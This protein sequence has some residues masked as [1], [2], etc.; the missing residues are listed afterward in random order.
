MSDLLP[1]F[2]AQLERRAGELDR[3]RGEA[4]AHATAPAA[5]HGQRRRRWRR[6]HG[7]GLAVVVL[8]AGASVGGLAYAAATT[9]WQPPLGNG[10][11]G[12]ATATASPVPAEQLRA[13]GVL[14]R[15]QT[16]LDRNVTTRY[17]LQFNA[18][19]E[20]VRTNAVRRLATGTSGGAIVLV[21]Y[22]RR[23]TTMWGDPQSPKPEALGDVLCLNYLDPFASAGVK[24]GTLNDV[25][26]GKMGMG[27]GNPECVT[28]EQRRSHAE[29]QAQE[30]RWARLERRPAQTL[31]CRRARD[32]K[33][34]THWVGVV[35]D[36]VASVKLGKRPNSRVV[37][38]HDNVF[39][40]DGGSG[41]SRD[42]VWLDAA[43]QPI[44]RQRAALRARL[45]LPP[46]PA[47]RS[48]G[49]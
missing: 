49:G 25:I 12:S 32:E 17:A 27:M 29:A 20:R 44:P 35:P 24:C 43:G 19:G 33:D 18:A 10:P 22:E 2:R 14:R 45:G 4:Q 46:E 13:L 5:E 11:A 48:R 3:G 16:E 28:P 34:V 26:A 21:P 8:L 37:P 9:L 47:R 36:G 38:V 23:V 1:G 31:P 15:A 39:Q 42:H 41:F 7:R 40:S 6:P 30:R